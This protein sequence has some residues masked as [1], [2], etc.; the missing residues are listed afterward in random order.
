MILSKRITAKRRDEKP[1]I[2]ASNKI[3]KMMRLVM[4]ALL[5]TEATLRGVGGVFEAVVIADVVD[6]ADF[7]VPTCCIVFTLHPHANTTQQT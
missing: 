6:D 4:P 2:H 7:F 5:F 3:R 1:A